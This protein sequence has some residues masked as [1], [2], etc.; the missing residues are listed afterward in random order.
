MVRLGATFFAICSL[1]VGGASAQEG[2][3]LSASAASAYAKSVRN[4]GKIVASVDCRNTSAV[5]AVFKP[6]IKIVSAANPQKRDWQL[7][8]YQGNM[9]YQPGP[10]NQWNQWR[11]VVNKVLA[12]GGGGT[13]YHCSL[14]HKK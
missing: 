6:E 14:F 13:Q 7:F 5:K 2:Q 3:W 8:L 1:F 12:G 9:D 10:P 4:A 11:R